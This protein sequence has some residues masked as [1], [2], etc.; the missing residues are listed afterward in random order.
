MLITVEGI[1]GAGK[2]T[3]VAGLADALSDRDPAVLREAAERVA[4]A[5]VGVEGVGV[6]RA[7]TVGVV[8]V[9]VEVVGVEGVEAGRAGVAFGVEQH[10]PVRAAA[11]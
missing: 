1:D 7:G 9:G 3:L 2:S 8:M 6:D 11:G 4:V 5:R 10:D